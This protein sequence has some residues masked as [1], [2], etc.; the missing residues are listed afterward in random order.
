VLLFTLGVA[1]VTGLL[2]GLVPALRAS[3]EATGETLKE[4]GRSGGARR[5]VR[6]ARGALVVSEVALATVMLTG[7][8]L[9]VRSLVHLQAIDLG[10]NANG[11]ISMQLAPIPDNYGTAQTVAFYQQV[12][13]RA[14]A[15]PGVVNAGAVGDLP[16][17]DGNSIWS[18]LLDGHAMTSVSEAPS[19]MPEDVTPGYFS[20]MGVPLLKGRLFTE[21]DR[22]GAPLVAV[23]NEA[24]VRKYWPD[25]DPIGRTLK[26]LNTKAPWVA[27]VGVVRDVKHN[28]YQGEI[29]PAM[30]FPHAQAA[31]SAYYAPT[32]MSVVVRTSGDPAALA[33]PMRKIVRE[34]DPTASVARLETMH[35][36]VAASV[37]SRRFSTELLLLFAALAMGLS[38]IG[39]YGVMSYSVSQ[40]SFELGLRMALGA[41]APQVLLL[42]V[43][44]GMLLALG[45]LAVG[46]VGAL[47]VAQLERAMF[48]DVGIADPFT[49]GSVALALMGVAGLACYVPARRATRLDPVAALRG[50]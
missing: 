4:G 1:L 18:I 47:G 5:G 16:V 49:I 50:G 30:Y 20:T 28:G 2:F 34:L 27:V 33:G 23:V 12:V 11:V 9:M 15:L 19:A 37:A 21:M 38:A 39:I 26:M 29:P 42:V 43:G 8:G 36:V 31:Q 35:E 17:A 24:M 46:L 6:R 40:R 25:V 44:E 32:T 41:Q 3:G 22:A 13:E 7:A 14:R 48:V 10:I 45:G